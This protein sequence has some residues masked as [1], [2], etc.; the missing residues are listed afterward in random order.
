MMKKF[1]SR[2]SETLMKMGILILHTHH[3]LLSLLLL[4]SS[5]LYS[6]NTFEKT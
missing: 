1:L 6:R 3:P 5:T 2:S 4:L